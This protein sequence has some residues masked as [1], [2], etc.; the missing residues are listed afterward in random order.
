MASPMTNN[1]S[2][3]ERRR[4][5]KLGEEAAEKLLL[6]SGYRIIA[7]NWRCRSG[8]LDLI[9]ELK[10]RLIFIEVRTRKASSRFGSPAE[11]IERRKRQRV[12]MLA[13]VYMTMNGIHDTP[14]RFDVIAVIL[15]RD[16]QIQAIDHYENAF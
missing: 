9:A 11:S 15:D 13:Q 1:P 3:D 7:R 8:E 6:S 10:D 4:T 12:R 5:G 2:G 16:S 14:V